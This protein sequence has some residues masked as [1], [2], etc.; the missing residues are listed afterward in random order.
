MS[1]SKQKLPEQDCAAVRRILDRV[2]DKWTALLAAR[3]GGLTIPSLGVANA[4][5]TIAS[6][7]MRLSAP[8]TEIFPG[9][10]RSVHIQR[11]AAW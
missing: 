10:N 9:V 5:P 4:A 11:W 3:R 1:P 2:G 8:V 7:Q 6:D